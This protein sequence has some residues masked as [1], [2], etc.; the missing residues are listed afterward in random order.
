MI[1]N[2]ICS[3]IPASFRN[4]DGTIEYKIIG[5]Y[6]VSIDQVQKVEQVIQVLA[7]I[8][9]DLNVRQQ[10]HYQAKILISNYLAGFHSQYHS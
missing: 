9:D 2:N 10:P 7:P 6:R 5:S 8:R 4:L 1:N 3:D